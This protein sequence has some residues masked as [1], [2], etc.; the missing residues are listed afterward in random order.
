[1][2][3]CIVVPHYNHVQQF[4]TVL[5]ELARKRLHLVIVDDHSPAEAFAALVELVDK[6]A[7]GSTLVR[8]SANHGKGGAVR[9]GLR[10]AQEM[11]YT[12]AVQIDADGQHD[13]SCIDALVT[14]AE[15]NPHRIVCGEPVFDEHMPALRY[16]A[17]YLT[18]YLCQLE[19]LSGEIRDPMCGFRVYPLSTTLGIC[20]R[21]RIGSRMDFDPEILVRAVWAGVSLSYV[22]V[23]VVYPQHGESHFHYLRDNILISWMHMRLIVGMLLRLPILMQRI[24]AARQPK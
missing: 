21:A 16:Y 1:M 8:L 24:W 19:T 12:H 9:S 20:D 18:L 13:L 3:V 17:R 2:K 5:P 23:K 22:P 4:T 15:L 14:E 11:G 10:T 6:C 7:P